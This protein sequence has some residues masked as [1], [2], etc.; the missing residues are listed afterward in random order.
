MRIQV[1]YTEQTVHL[2]PL[3]ICCLHFESVRYRV[4]KTRPCVWINIRYR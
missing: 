4:K 2:S 3:F 1:T